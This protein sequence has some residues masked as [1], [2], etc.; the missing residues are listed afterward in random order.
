VAD[1]ADIPA[2]IALFMG[3]YALGAAIGELRSPG[4]WVSMLED[5]G[6]ASGLRFLTGIFLIALGAAI[7]LTSPWNP[8]DWLAVLV[9]VMGGGMALEG[10]I[11]L[12]F[13]EPFFRF[14]RAMLGTISGRGWAL[15]SA[16]MGLALIGVA[17]ARL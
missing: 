1:A 5:Y 10:F 16:I 8:G 13:G 15:F 4:F 7:Y 12:A 3:L 9:T 14:A 6:A 11:V 17:I 2:W